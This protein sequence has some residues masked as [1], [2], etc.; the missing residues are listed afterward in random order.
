[1]TPRIPAKRIGGASESPIFMAVNVELQNRTSSTN[2]ATVRPRP[3]F[4]SVSQA[5][6]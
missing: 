3:P 4:K 6:G 1:M 5:L 2:A